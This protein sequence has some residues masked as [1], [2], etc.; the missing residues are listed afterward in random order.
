[1]AAEEV[2]ASDNNG[3]KHAAKDLLANPLP[4][5]S[6]ALDQGS[7]DSAA[8]SEITQAKTVVRG[9]SR[10]SQEV[11]DFSPRQGS[12]ASVAQVLL[13]QHL[14]HFFLEKLIGGGGMGESGTDTRQPRDNVRRYQSAED[15]T[16]EMPWEAAD[17]TVCIVSPEA[18]RQAQAKMGLGL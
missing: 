1:M 4:A 5:S 3:D 9:S 6:H 18:I 7:G 17:R 16:A 13:G 10:V 14:N 11:M 12:P 2:N 8:E 15:L